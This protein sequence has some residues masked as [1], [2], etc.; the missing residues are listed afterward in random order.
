MLSVR[1]QTLGRVSINTAQLIAT[2]DVDCGARAGAGYPV[3]TG[4][5][6]ELQTKI[7]RRSHKVMR[8]RDRRVG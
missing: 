3:V 4:Y 2:V 1:N 5:R 8:D 6:L 7:T